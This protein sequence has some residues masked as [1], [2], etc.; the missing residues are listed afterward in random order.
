MGIKIAFGFEL[1]FELLKSHCQ[2]TL[3]IGLDMGCD[4]LVLSSRSIYPHRALYDN[5]LSLDQ[6]KSEFR[7]RGFPHHTFECTLV[8]FN[9]KVEMPTGSIGDLCNLPFNHDMHKCSFEEGFNLGIKR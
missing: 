2:S 9:S 7:D 6:L 4:K 1:G 8:I 5:M 3:A